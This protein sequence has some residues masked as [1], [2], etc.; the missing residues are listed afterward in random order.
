MCKYNAT[1]ERCQC[2]T[3]A[4]HKLSNMKARY[5]AITHTTMP[6][7]IAYRIVNDMVIHMI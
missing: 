5:E 6:Y 2:I 1:E 7:L 3:Q 4:G